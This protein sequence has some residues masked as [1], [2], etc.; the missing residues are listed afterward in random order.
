VL[1]RSLNWRACYCPGKVGAILPKVAFLAI[2]IAPTVTLHTRAGVSQVRASTYIALY[3]TLLR[4]ETPRPLRLMV[5]SIIWPPPLLVPRSGPRWSTNPLWLL[6]LLWT[7]T[8]HLPLHLLHNPGLL[9][10]TSEI[11]DGQ[12]SHHQT[13]IA[14]ETILKL[15]ASPLLIKWQGVETAEV[16]E[17]LSILRHGLSPL[18]Q[19]EEFHLLG[20]LNVVRKVLA[21][22]SLPESLP[23]HW[24]ISLLKDGFGADPPMLRFPCEHIHRERQLVLCG[25]HLCIID[26]L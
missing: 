21:E 12:G 6:W 1:V 23:R 9:H 7:L 15:F 3:S 25:A 2:V 18:S 26:A 19:L 20:V 8:F 11:L 4:R 16:L 17:S 24:L 22:E 13:D 14:A 10:Q 5:G